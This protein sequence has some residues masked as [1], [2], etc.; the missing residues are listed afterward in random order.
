VSLAGI[1]AADGAAHRARA[2]PG[3]HEVS[4][5]RGGV[6]SGVQGRAGRCERRTCAAGQAHV[7]V[8]SAA[9]DGVASAT[10]G[11]GARGR[12][13]AAAM[14]CL[15]GVGRDGRRSGAQAAGLAAKISPTALAQP[16]RVV[17]VVGRR[18]APR[19][20][21]SPLPAAP[22]PP[23]H[24]Q[25]PPASCA[26]APHTRTTPNSLTCSSRRR[27]RH[28]RPHPRTRARTTQQDAPQPRAERAVC[29]DRVH[30]HGGLPDGLQGGPRERPPARAGPRVA[31]GPL[32]L[33]HLV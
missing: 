22:T 9:V 32:V 5:R 14:A 24:H 1:W 15:R 12:Q 7:C 30:P 33:L 17:S 18:R 13:H 8:G 29:A 25:H 31:H 2:Q 4:G 20:A 23:S 16:A 26:H 28:L 11:T 10:D 21:R 3:L 27:C 6:A 19:A